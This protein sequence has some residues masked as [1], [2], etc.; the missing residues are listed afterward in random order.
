MSNRQ[1]STLVAFAENSA[2]L[3]PSPSQ[4]APSGCG[5]PSATRVFEVEA[6]TNRNTP[7]EDADAER[8]NSGHKAHLDHRGSADATLVMRAKPSSTQAAGR[9][10]RA[11]SARATPGRA[12]SGKPG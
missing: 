4:V 9:R 10:D 5:R 1:S 3:T 2:K 7:F 6:D 11:A 12:P 8:M